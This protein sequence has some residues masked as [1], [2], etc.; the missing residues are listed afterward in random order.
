[1]RCSRRVSGL[2]CRSVFASL[3]SVQNQHP[4][5]AVN[6]CQTHANIHLE[7]SPEESGKLSLARINPAP[8]ARIRH[9]WTSTQK[10][11]FC[12]VV[13]LFK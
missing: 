6:H 7:T 5:D 3:R 1:M 13:N 11:R 10:L 2:R 12:I 9:S 8:T 4:P